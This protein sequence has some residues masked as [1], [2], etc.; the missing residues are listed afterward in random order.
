MTLPY[1][2]ESVVVRDRQ[3]PDAELLVLGGVGWPPAGH[4]AFSGI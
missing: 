2:L 1:P 4:R 3:L